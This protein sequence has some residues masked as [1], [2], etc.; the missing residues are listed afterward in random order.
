MLHF[1]QGSRDAKGTFCL[2][3]T[4]SGR[5]VEGCEAELRDLEEQ[6]DEDEQLFPVSDVMWQ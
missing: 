4:V 3:L 2:F 6:L 5:K 1:K